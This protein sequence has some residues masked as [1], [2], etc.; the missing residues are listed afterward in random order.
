MQ[1]TIAIGD[2]EVGRL[3]YGAMRLCGT[4]VWGEPADPAAARALLREVV[5]L[6][7]TLIDTSDAYGP[8]VNERQI[9]EA[10]HPYPADL[11]VATKGGYTRPSA[12]RWVP[13]G[14]PE[15]L[16]AAC[17][18]SLQRLNVD[19]IDLYQLHTPDSNVPF[20]ES[21]GA[22]KRLR[23]E[24]KV[25]NVGL[26][27][28]DVAQLHAA[29]KIVPIVSVQNSYNVG[30]RESEDVVQACAAQG[31][32]FLAYFPID[33]GALAKAKGPLAEIA[34]AHGATTAQVA[35][36]WLLQHSPAVVPIPGTSSSAHLRENL[37]A[38]SITL[39]DAELKTLDAIAA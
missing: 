10:L 31:I 17:A 15:H 30:D 12:G 26:S 8:E 29:Q 27:N 19:H 6:G 1:Q 32:A 39:S 22:L 11:L 24:G 34:R 36:A 5:E 18:A 7:I 9:A 35:L 28:V 23:D 14:R 33:A 4:G 16:L 2:F 13:D 3:A 38:A 21:V 37:G 25:R 20:E